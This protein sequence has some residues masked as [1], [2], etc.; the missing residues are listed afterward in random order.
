[1]LMES[2]EYH[3]QRDPPTIRNE[4]DGQISPMLGYINTSLTSAV[5]A[6]AAMT[7]CGYLS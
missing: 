6:V 5:V 4:A 7:D 3:I 1:M 2:I